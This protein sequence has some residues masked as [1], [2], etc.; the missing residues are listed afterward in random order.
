MIEVLYS[1]PPID[2]R[3]APCHNFCSSCMET[4]GSKDTPVLTSACESMEGSDI[5]AIYIRLVNNI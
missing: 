2:Q 4:V 3:Q 1:A 5:R